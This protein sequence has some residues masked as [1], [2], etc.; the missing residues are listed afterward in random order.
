M[1]SP[2]AFQSVV[3]KDG[4]KLGY[5]E[6]GDPAGKPIFYFPGSTASGLFAQT[7]HAAAAE[8]GARIVAPDRPG[9]GISDFRPGRALGDWPADIV[10]L[11][12]ALGISRFAVMSE[13]GGSPYAAVCAFRI[14][15][16][17]TAAAIVAGLSPLEAPG[18]LQGMSAQNRSALLL[19]QKVPYGLLRLL[20]WPTAL[21]LR[22][23]PEKLLPQLS[24]SA[25]LMPEADRAIYA[26]LAFQKTVLAAFRAA[27]QQGARG[28]VWDTRL[29][30]QPWGFQ[31]RDIQIAV[32]LWHGEADQN[33]P[34]AMARYMQGALLKCQATYYP[35]EGHV[36]VMHQH[37]REILRALRGD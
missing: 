29:C 31:L 1:P 8:T 18:V 26:D 5:A 30:T 10:E 21:T 37:G 32:Q 15:E 20:Y 6:F 12:E 11:A 7:L 16:R 9:I 17:L 24:Q 28:P 22:R 2:N 25:K 35:G 33:A 34:V 13:S 23:S 36:S 4:R 19:C 14:P 27:F 3:L